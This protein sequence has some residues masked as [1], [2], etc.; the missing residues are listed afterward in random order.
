[1]VNRGNATVDDSTRLRVTIVVRVCSVG[2]VE[3]GVVAFATDDDGEGRIVHLSW[4]VELAEGIL[5]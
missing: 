3:A 4:L 1:M 5:D 2:G